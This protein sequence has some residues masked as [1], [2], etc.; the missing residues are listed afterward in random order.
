MSGNISD[1]DRVLA[2]AIEAG[3]RTKYHGDKP[4]CRCGGCHANDTYTAAIESLMSGKG[5][6]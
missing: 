3:R 6:K 5:D 1:R 2:E 4:K